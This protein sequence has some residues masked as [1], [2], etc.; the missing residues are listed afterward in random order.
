MRLAKFLPC[1]DH[2]GRTCIL[3]QRDDKQ[4]RFIPLDIAEGLKLV[5]DSRKRFDERFKELP[6]Y[7]AERICQ[8]YARYA[9]E[10]GATKE[11]MLE[12]GKVVRVTKEQLERVTTR[13]TVVKDADGN[14]VLKA[15]KR[16][17]RQQ[18]SAAQMFRDLILAGQ[19]TDDQIFQQVQQTFK[20]DASR[21]T[22]VDW[23]RKQLKK[24]GAD[25]PAPKKGK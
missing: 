6:E 5:A 23:Y 7:P 15:T 2:Q 21:R 10:I 16:G 25:V 1:V 11:A 22:Y 17:E 19:L 12:L 24:Q 20:L 18:G 8:L 3:V 4:A 13:L 14:R 9:D